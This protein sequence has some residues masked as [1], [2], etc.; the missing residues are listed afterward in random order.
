M[1]LFS[2]T[3]LRMLWI[4]ATIWVSALI[5]VNSA[6]YFQSG[7]TPVFLL[8]KGALRDWPL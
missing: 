7:P 3:R 5:I 1:F 6:I 8:E 4:V 2:K